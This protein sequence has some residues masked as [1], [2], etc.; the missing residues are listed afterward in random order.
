[1]INRDEHAAGRW[2][3]Q[4]WENNHGKTN[5]ENEDFE[6]FSEDC[7]KCWFK[8]DV[9]ATLAPC[10][11]VPMPGWRIGSEP[12]SCRRVENLKLQATRCLQ[13]SGQIECDH[14][15]GKL[16]VKP[17]LGNKHVKTCHGKYI[18]VWYSTTVHSAVASA[19][20]T[21]LLHSLLNNR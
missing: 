5:E 18:I 12:I 10:P 16:Q 14:N 7:V 4:M 13:R 21:S 1:M 3:P 6:K 2:R 9:S 20:S 17:P 8:E 15:V 11:F 19:Q